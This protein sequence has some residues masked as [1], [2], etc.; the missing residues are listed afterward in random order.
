MFFSGGN[1]SLILQILVLS[2]TSTEGVCADICKRQ[3]FP[4]TDDQMSDKIRQDHGLGGQ[5]SV[6]H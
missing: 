1:I 3:E 2:L 4:D 5:K 6:S